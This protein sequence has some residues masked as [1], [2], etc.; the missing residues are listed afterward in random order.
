VLD[1][2]F[3]TLDAPP[4]GRPMFGLHSR[5]FDAPPFRWLMFNDPIDP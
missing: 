3:Y 5:N 1:V 4:F 2:Q